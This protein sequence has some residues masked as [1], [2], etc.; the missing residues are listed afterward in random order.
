MMVIPFTLKG[1][2]EDYVLLKNPNST[3]IATIFIVSNYGRSIKSDSDLDFY[4]S[5]C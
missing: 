5:I 2:V 1:H 4:L 3:N